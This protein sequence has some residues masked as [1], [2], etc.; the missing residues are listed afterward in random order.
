MQ[1][2]LYSHESRIRKSSKLLIYS[3]KS[4]I[5]EFDITILINTNKLVLFNLPVPIISTKQL[6]AKSGW[7]G[8]RTG[9]PDTRRLNDAS[10]YCSPLKSS[11]EFDSKLCS[12]IS[13]I[14][15][16]THSVTAPASIV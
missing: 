9:S 4:S 15:G 1:F 7:F 6:P 16:N 11:F 3:N 10:Y 13:T 2:S 12:I 8:L 14:I 5:F